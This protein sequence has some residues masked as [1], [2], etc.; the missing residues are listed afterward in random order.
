MVLTAGV[1]Y[2]TLVYIVYKYYTVNSHVF[3]YICLD[4]KIVC[5]AKMLLT[6]GVEYNTLVY[7]YTSIIQ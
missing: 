7:M 4:Y 1:E 5:L 6:A 3:V 2:N